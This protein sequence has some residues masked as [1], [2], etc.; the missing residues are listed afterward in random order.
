MVVREEMGSPIRE[1]GTYS[2]APSISKEF[3]VAS[4]TFSY[5]KC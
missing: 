3:V 4:R 2:I 1:E 5:G